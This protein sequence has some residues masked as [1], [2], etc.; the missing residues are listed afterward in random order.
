MQLFSTYLSVCM[1]VT[2][3]DMESSSFG[4]SDPVP[5]ARGC[6]GQSAEGRPGGGDRGETEGKNRALSGT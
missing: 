6:G 3:S 4:L 2:L 1:F 5:F